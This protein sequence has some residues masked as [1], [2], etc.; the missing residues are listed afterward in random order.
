MT[1]VPRALAV[2][3]GLALAAGLTLAAGR[4]LAARERGALI[5]APILHALTTIDVGPSKAELAAVLGAPPADALA[6]LTSYAT[7]SDDDGL[8][9]RAIRAIPSFCDGELAACHAAIVAAIVAAAG[10]STDPG[11][12][13]AQQQLRIRAAIEALGAIRAP[14]PS[15]V[16]RLLG[17]LQSISRDLRVAAARAL[18]DLCDPDTIGPLEQRLASEPVEQVRR[19]IGQTVTLI[20]L[21]QCGR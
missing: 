19:A 2:T 21:A 16:P 3:A 11:T 6:L 8:P 15:D 12:L 5:A 10:N 9:I 14:D 1:P 4:A 13:G 20:K 17:Y 18:G 7:D